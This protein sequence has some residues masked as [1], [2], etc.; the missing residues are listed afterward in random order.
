MRFAIFCAFLLLAACQPTPAPEMTDTQRAAIEQVIRQQGE[1]YLASCAS[2]DANRMFAHFAEDDASYVYNGVVD[3]SYEAISNHCRRVES[4]RELQ[5]EWDQVRVYV[6]SP[7]AAVFHGKF[8]VL[9]TYSDGKT[10]YFP[11]AFWT[12]LYK[13]RDGEWKMV[14]VHSSWD[15]SSVEGE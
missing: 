14:L 3:S 10:K 12:V 4:M 15:P 8:H 6:L 11:E 2:L 9:H 5:G 1:E 13:H 7:D